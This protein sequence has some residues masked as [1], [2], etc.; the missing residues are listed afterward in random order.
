[1]TRCDMIAV[2]RVVGG[3]YVDVMRTEQGTNLKLRDAHPDAERFRFIGASDH[4][5]VIVGQHH[6]GL[7]L[8]AS[9]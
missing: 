5:A 2:E 3:E 8:P 1:M 7:A 6:N 4:T 9:G